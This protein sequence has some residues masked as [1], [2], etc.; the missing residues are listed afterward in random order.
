[1]DVATMIDTAAILL[2]LGALGGVLMLFHR[3]GQTRNPPAWLAMVHGFAA[4][5]GLTLLVYAWCAVGLP[6]LAQASVVL[7][8]LAALGGVV[9]NLRDHWNH[10]LLSRGL[11]IG[12][13]A[14]AVVGYALL[15]LA[16]FAG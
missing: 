4:A 16:A 7:L 8:A 6:P 11:V 14:I 15:L 9:L 12:H 13:L 2:G 5:A 1:M 3:F 10:V